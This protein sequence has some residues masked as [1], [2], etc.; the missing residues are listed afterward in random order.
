MS[1]SFHSSYPII[2]LYLIFQIHNKF[3][4]N[5]QLNCHIMTYVCMNLVHI[6]QPIISCY[7]QRK[8]RQLESQLSAINSN[9][10]FTF[11]C[12]VGIILVYIHLYCVCVPMSERHAA[13]FMSG[14]RRDQ[15]QFAIQWFTFAMIT[16]YVS[17][18]LLLNTV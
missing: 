10:L 2:H 11:F 13:S 18:F 9:N 12:A 15:S 8:K 3:C 6:L 4:L 16:Y 14:K 17:G 1:I 5:T 7:Y